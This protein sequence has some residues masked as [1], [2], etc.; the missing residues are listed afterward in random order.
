MYEHSSHLVDF[1][2]NSF[3]LDIACLAGR[4]STIGKHRE[5]NVVDKSLAVNSDPTAGEASQNQS[6]WLQYFD[7][8]T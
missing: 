4:M 3:S 1:H 8:Q 7:K 2:L 5:C 6:E